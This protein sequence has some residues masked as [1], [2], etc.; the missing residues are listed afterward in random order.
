VLFAD[1]VGFISLS[2][3]LEPEEVVRTQQEN[4]GPYPFLEKAGPGQLA[5]PNRWVMCFYTLVAIICIGLK[6][7]NNKLL[8]G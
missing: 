6:N 3:R 1:V 5:E 4:W 2:E 8:F 7:N